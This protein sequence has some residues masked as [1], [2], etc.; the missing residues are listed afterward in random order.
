[1]PAHQPL[2]RLGR[3]FPSRQPTVR[4]RSFFFRFRV[5]GVRVISPASLLVFGMPQKPKCQLTR[6][7]VDAPPHQPRGGGGGGRPSTTHVVGRES[8]ELPRGGRG[9]YSGNNGGQ[10]HGH[11]GA[12]PS[13]GWSSNNPGGG[14]G[15]GMPTHRISRSHREDSRNAP[16]RHHDH[17][18][19]NGLPPNLARHHYPM[20]GGKG[21]T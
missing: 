19:G 2:T 16:P 5:K 15:G 14:G 8:W 9:Q 12:P 10:H 4:Y 17:A 21:L 7:P 11:G 1:M 20:I 18:V 3:S 6:Y 13:R